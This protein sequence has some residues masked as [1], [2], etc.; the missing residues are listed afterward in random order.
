MIV[1]RRTSWFAAYRWLAIGTGVG[2]FLRILTSLAIIRGSYQSGTIY[3]FAWFVPFLCYAGAALAAPVS[4]AESE[5]IEAPSAPL[6]VVISAVPVF[7]IPL[8][9]YCAFTCSRLAPP[10]THSAPC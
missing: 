4:P 3:D 7:L 1:A 5:L 9:G 10:T 2:F 6:H 8:I